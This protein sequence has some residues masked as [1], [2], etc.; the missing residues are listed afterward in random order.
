MN[1]KFTKCFLIERGRWRG[2]MRGQIIYGKIGFIVR[3]KPDG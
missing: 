2:R 1:T 3:R